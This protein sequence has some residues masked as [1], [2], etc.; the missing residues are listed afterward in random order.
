MPRILL[1]AERDF[2]VGDRDVRRCTIPHRQYEIMV[3][4]L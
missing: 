4:A 2:I 1:G 3:A